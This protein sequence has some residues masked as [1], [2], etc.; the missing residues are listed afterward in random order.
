MTR[1]Y[2][3]LLL[4]IV[5]IPSAGCGKTDSAGSGTAESPLGS[6]TTA[7]KSG[8]SSAIGQVVQKF[9][10]AVR[11]GNTEVASKL[12][13]PLALKR[14]SELDMNISPPGSSTAKFSVGELEMIDAQRAIVRSIWT[15]LDADGKP[16]SEQI[17]WALKQSDGVWRI[18]GMAAEVGENQPPVVVDFE[19]PT[20]LANSNKQPPA[21]EKNSPRLARDPFQK[22]TSH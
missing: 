6:T 19:N 21:T 11:L 16:S 7:T 14:T 10:N 12:L 18:S 1:N 9:L 8:E 15:D 20:E 3:L 2:A 17:T 13:T 4:L 5:F 22:A